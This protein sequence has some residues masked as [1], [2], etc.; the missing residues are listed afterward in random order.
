MRLWLI[1]QIMTGTLYAM[2]FAGLVF[3]AP[4]AYAVTLYVDKND[5]NCSNSGAGSS[6][7]PFCSIG[8]AAARV[9]AGDD[10]VVR[11]ASYAERVRITRS[12]TASAPI[13]FAGDAGAT[14]TGQLYGFDIAA[15]W[16]TIQGF[17]VTSTTSDGI[18]CILCS[19]VTINSNQ[20]ADAQG[21]GLYI[22]DSSNM[23]LTDNVVQRSESHGIYMQNDTNFTISG[24]SVSGSGQPVQ[25]QTKKGIYVTGCSN[26]IITGTEVFDNSDNGIYLIEGT[27]GVRVKRTVT[28]GNAR[29]WSRAAAGVETR[30]DGNII[31][32]NI[33]YDNEDSAIN[34]RW[35]GSNALVFNNIG[36]G[37]GDHGIDVLESPGARIIGNSVFDNVAAGINV[38][39][40]SPGATIVNN[41]SVDN[42]INSPR[43][44][45]NIRVTST[46]TDGTIAD[47]NI[48]YQSVSARLYHWNGT[49]YQSLATLHN[50]Y[51]NVEVHAIQADP[52]WVAPASGDFHLRAGSPAIDSA[53]SGVSDAPSVDA[54]GHARCDDPATVNTGAGPRAYDDRGAL[55]L[56]AAGCSLAV[57]SL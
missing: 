30:S 14:V 7:Q 53:N 47:Y 34:M 46:S 27:K 44:E 13:T 23:T 16:V 41:I 50:T 42:G 19:N 26:S 40:N 12:G 57:G 33:G 28:H 20:V 8:T 36:Y 3:L 31:E 18:R 37:N 24:G 11:A 17:T 9:V 48:V 51:P 55:E 39:G 10:V 43:T 38:E 21:K 22:R 6:A 32:S 54:E 15:Q 4:T 5:Q 29:G 56:L 2:G 35:G 25:D 52:A 1:A 45:G 49:Y